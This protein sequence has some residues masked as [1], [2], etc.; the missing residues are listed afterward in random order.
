VIGD[1]KLF[2]NSAVR[3]FLLHIGRYVCDVP[4]GSGPVSWTLK[5]GPVS[6]RF[7]GSVAA[8][9]R[10]LCVSALKFLVG[11]IY[12]FIESLD[13]LLCI[14]KRRTKPSGSTSGHESWETFNE[15]VEEAGTFQDN[16]AEDIGL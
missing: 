11:R 8:W 12:R 4:I 13:E 6:S 2:D 7:R 15:Y 10:A 14:I 5:A 3:H 1:V 16:P 9:P